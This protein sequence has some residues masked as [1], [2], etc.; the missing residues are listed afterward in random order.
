MSA[1]LREMYSSPASHAVHASHKASVLTV[2]HTLVNKP[3]SP[4][5][6][7]QLLHCVLPISF[8]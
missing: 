8:L 4:E 6:R 7:V 1:H 5:Q 2:H 3:L